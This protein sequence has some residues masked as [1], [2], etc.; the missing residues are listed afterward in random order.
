MNRNIWTVV[1]LGTLT[2]ACGKETKPEDT[3]REA[4]DLAQIARAEAAVMAPFQLAVTPA[5]TPAQVA[6]AV[7]AAPPF[8]GEDRCDEAETIDEVRVVVPLGDCQSAFGV[9]GLQGDIKVDYYVGTTGGVHLRGET[10]MKAGGGRLGFLNETVG[11]PTSTTFAIRTEGTSQGGGET[12]IHRY[13]QQTVSADPAGG[14]LGLEGQWA[15]RGDHHQGTAFLK[16]FRQ[17]QDRCPEAGGV[18]ELQ[19]APGEVVMTVSFD[20]TA[21]A[22]WSGGEASGTFALE[23]ATE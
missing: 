14:C 2:L 20:G 4:L 18:V 7:K 5:A 9:A 16:N 12:D 19:E 1:T 17:C 23:C 15:S 13:G 11:D 3:A 21:T 6:E 10:G 8:Q 22:T